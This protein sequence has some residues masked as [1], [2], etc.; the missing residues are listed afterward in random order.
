MAGLPTI[1][2]WAVQ[3]EMAGTSPAITNLITNVTA[4]M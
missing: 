2:T 4:F 3:N 1:L